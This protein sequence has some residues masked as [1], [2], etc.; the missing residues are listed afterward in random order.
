MARKR[1]S[2]AHGGGHG[3]YVTFADL[4]ALL[5]AF[6]VMIAAFSTMN[7]E[8]MQQA[9]G[10]MREA[11][12][13]QTKNEVN[14]GVIEINGV[15]VRSYPKSVSMTNPMESSQ[16]PGLI[17]QLEN[18]PL[19]NGRDNEFAQA[20]TSIRQALQDMPELAEISQRIVVEETEEGLAIQITDQDGRSMF[21]EGSSELYQRVRSA[22]SGLATLL[23]RLPQR[24]S[25]AGHTAASR[26]QSRRD[27]GPWEL[28]ADRANAVRRVLVEGGLPLDRIAAVTGRAET[29]PLYPDNPYL[30]SNR[31][32]KITLLHEAPPVP[33]G[34]EP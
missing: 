33:V 34:V 10:S 12:G 27:Y 11:F 23:Q 3:W 26:A 29:Q 6:F 25:I 13:V 22:L 31:R 28:S 16:N 8:K 21:P 5:M 4:M 20:A 2:E 1:K 30:P 17:M 32:I 24:V 18:G 15:P 7:Q 9:L 19:R 14:G